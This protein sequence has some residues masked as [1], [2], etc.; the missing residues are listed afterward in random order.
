VR[1]FSTLRRITT[2]IT[3]RILY[4]V[5]IILENIDATIR[6]FFWGSMNA[7]NFVTI[8]ILLYNYWWN[9]CSHGRGVS[10]IGKSSIPSCNIL[11]VNISR[12]W[13]SMSSWM[14]KCYACWS[15]LYYTKTRNR[16]PNGISNVPPDYVPHQI[17]IFMH[18]HDITFLC[19]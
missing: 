16:F 15:F 9:C 3:Q 19:W 2:K 1:N 5:Q 8:Y 14:V 13:C 17:T 12:N 11:V 4:V 10:F 6:S 7:M 18:P